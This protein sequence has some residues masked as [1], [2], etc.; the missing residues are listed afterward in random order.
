MSK[1]FNYPAHQLDVSKLQLTENP[2]DDYQRCYFSMLM[3]SARGHRLILSSLH[4]EL[5]IEKV[6]LRLSQHNLDVKESTYRTSAVQTFHGVLHQDAGADSGTAVKNSSHTS[7][8]GRPGNKTSAAKKDALMC[9]EYQLPDILQWEESRILEPSQRLSQL[10]K[11]SLSTE[12]EEWLVKTLAMNGANVL[13]GY[14]TKSAGER[15]LSFLSK[16]QLFK[17]RKMQY[18]DQEQIT[19][20]IS[21]VINPNNCILWDHQSGY[22]F[23]TGIWRLYQDVMRGL[24]VVDRNHDSSSEC[25]DE[26]CHLEARKEHCQIELEYALSR[27]FYEKSPAINDSNRVNRRRYAPRK[28][29][30]LSQSLTSPLHYSDI[31]WNQLNKEFQ[32]DLVDLY[33]TAHN[34]PGNVEF[35][36]IMKRIRGGYIKIQ[37][38]WLPYEVSRELCLRFCYPIRYL[39]VPIFGPTFPQECVNW[40]DE[41]VALYRDRNMF[42]KFM[43]NAKRTSFEVTREETSFHEPE[44]PRTKRRASIDEVLSMKKPKM[45]H[46]LLDASK[47]LLDISRRSSLQDHQPI[48]Q[49][50]QQPA[51]PVKQQRSLSWTPEYRRSSSRHEQLPSIRSLLDS[52]GSTAY[53]SPPQTSPRSERNS[54]IT[55]S[56]QNYQISTASMNDQNWLNSS[57]KS[58]APVHFYNTQQ[59]PS[60]TFSNMAYFYNTNGHRYSYPGGMHVIYQVPTAIKDKKEA[61]ARAELYDRR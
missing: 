61:K 37:G 31:H 2:L 20:E 9:L 45:D 1:L 21:Q 51:D 58:T 27:C 15:D 3:N 6:L 33:K 36:D 5:D 8:S 44:S 54:I 53:S 32:T 57:E 50:Y 30:H 28:P 24:I 49:D 11:F 35:S 38:T 48:F 29:R 7:A 39:L 12:Q 52:L 4:N 17:M 46:E 23:F 59:R 13:K 25:H 14:S 40:Y 34:F 26:P 19:Q 10:E 43:G 55:P 47:N 22:V 41:H 18:A 60:Q 42:S 16:N 56:P